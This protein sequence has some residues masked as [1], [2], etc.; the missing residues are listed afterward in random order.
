MPIEKI[1]KQNYLRISVFDHRKKQGELTLIEFPKSIDFLQD[2]QFQ[3]YRDKTSDDSA[4]D[5]ADDVDDEAVVLDL[6][7]EVSVAVLAPGSPFLAE[8]A[9]CFLDVFQSRGDFPEF[10]FVLFLVHWSTLFLAGH[11]S[12]RPRM[13]ARR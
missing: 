12:S 7:S 10:S 5:P 13:P 3:Q 8:I 1:L 2:K 11:V 9:Q 4:G 6:F